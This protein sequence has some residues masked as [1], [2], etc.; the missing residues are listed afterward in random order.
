[1]QNQMLTSRK[2]GE[3]ISYKLDGIEKIHQGQNCIDE[4][5]KV[6]WKRHFPVLFPIVGKLKQNKTII[7]GRTYEMC[8]HGFARDLDFEPITKLDNFHSYVLRSNPSTLVKYPFDFSLYITYR[9]DENKLTTI[10]KVVNEGENNMP[11]GIGGHPAFIIDQKDLYNEEYYLEFEEDENKIHFLYLID[12]LI[13]TDYAKNIMIDKR[14]IKITKNSFDNDAII[15]K[16]ITSRKI[17]LKKRTG[18]KTL[19]T[20]DFEG[21]QYLGIWSKPGAPFICIEPWKTTADT[22]KST[23][24]FAQKTDTITLAPKKEFECR[25]TV[26][27]FN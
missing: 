14:R 3:L 16:G 8:Q 27:F 21:F 12:G 26:E 2:G 17:S 22:V 24:V 10:Y 25:Y 11:F 4:N 9:T 23:G 15:I 19:L 5:G 7:N 20:M 1:M 13:G 6:Y 18:N